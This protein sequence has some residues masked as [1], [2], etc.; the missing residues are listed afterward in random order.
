MPDDVRYYLTHDGRW[1]FGIEAGDGNWWNTEHEAEQALK[2][3]NEANKE[4]D[5]KSEKKS[6]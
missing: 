3:F 2:Q 5:R 4:I 1:T 6:D